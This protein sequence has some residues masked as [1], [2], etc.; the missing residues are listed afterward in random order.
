MKLRRIHPL[1]QP[2]VGRQ[3]LPPLLFVHDG[4]ATAACWRA[5]AVVIPRSGHAPMLDAHWQAAAERI[6]A[7]IEQ[8]G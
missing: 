5:V 7:W 6:A 4:Y 3:R 2:A 8:Q 1:H